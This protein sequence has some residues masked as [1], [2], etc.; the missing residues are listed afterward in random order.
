VLVRDGIIAAVWKGAKPPN[1]VDLTG[2]VRA[3]LGP[4]AYIYP[5]LINLHDHPF[6]G[7]LPLWQPPSSHRQPGLGRPLGTEPYGNRYQWNSAGVTQP[8]EAGRLISNPSTILADRAGLDRLIDVV[9]FTKARMILGG[10]TTTQNTG[11]HAAYDSLLARNVESVTFGR[12][13]IS[14]HAGCF[15]KAIDVTAP[16]VPDGSDTLAQVSA[17]ITDGSRA[18]G[19]DHPAAGGG[20]SSPFTNTWSYLK[21]RIPGASVLPDLTFNLVSRTTLE[22]RLDR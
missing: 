18:L 14:S 1:G 9:K 20:P 3:P 15:D 7:V 12:Q 2:V 13:R 4:H 21:A 10:T 8:E 5:G 11:S 19:G 6:Y 17:R 16:S 22:R